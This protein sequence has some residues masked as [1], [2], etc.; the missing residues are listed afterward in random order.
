MAAFWAT[1][2]AKLFLAT[3]AFAAAFVFELLFMDMVFDM[4][5]MAFVFKMLFLAFIFG[6]AF[7]MARDLGAMTIR[8]EEQG[9]PKQLPR[10]A[11]PM[12]VTIITALLA[13]L[14]SLS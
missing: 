12:Q 10:D 9:A 11:Y 13:V 2:F 8:E 3:F 4:L 5:F 6:A 7:F 1:R 14:L